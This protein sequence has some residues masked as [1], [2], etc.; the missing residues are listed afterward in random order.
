MALLFCDGFEGYTKTDCGKFWG[1]TASTSGS[2]IDATGRRGGGAF[3][4]YS[5]NSLTNFE[6][7]WFNPST[8]DSQILIVGLAFQINYAGNDISMIQFGDTGGGAYAGGLTFLTSNRLKL[9]RKAVLLD[10]IEYI[11]DPLD[12]NTW[13]Y[14]EMKFKI[15]GTEGLGELRLNEQ[16][17]Y[18]FS[19]KDTRPNLAIDNQIGI[20]TIRGNS[21]VNLHY[22]DIYILDTTGSNNNDF[23]GDVRIDMINPNGAG[24]YSQL[25]PSAGSNYECVDESAFD[26]SDYVEGANAA[27]KDSYSYENVPTDLDD[28]SIFGIQLNNVS[29]KTAEADNIKMKGFLR[30]G[31]TDYEET[32]AQSLND[33]YKNKQMIWE[34]DPSDSNPWTQAKINACEFGVEVSN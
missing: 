18:S 11:S 2:T 10:E 9:W 5:G 3:R 21:Y 20:V 6:L 31:S 16:S 33:S 4:A 25:T 8:F 1:Y 27:E 29:Q 22:D 7:R 12:L 15:H 34:D 26:D 24:N 23:L 13:Y 14:V 19:D 28:A 17:L 30:T 32:T